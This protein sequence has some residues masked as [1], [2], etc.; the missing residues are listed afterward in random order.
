MLPKKITELV[1][2]L[3]KKTNAG[4]LIWDYDDDNSSVSLN[5]TRFK[6]TISY[7][8]NNIE[9]VGQFRVIYTDKETRKTH[10]FNTNESYSDYE[11]VRILFD[12][13][14]ASGLDID[15]LDEDD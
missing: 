7:S 15:M 3:I 11:D 13:A 12:N 10:F 6:I 4:E 8:F 1:I 14:Q 2:K 5:H 9:E